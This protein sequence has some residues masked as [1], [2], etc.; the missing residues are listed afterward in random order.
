MSVWDTWVASRCL[1]SQIARCE[2]LFKLGMERSDRAVAIIQPSCFVAISLPELNFVAG[3]AVEFL[4]LW[5]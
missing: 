5:Y 2:T 4:D 1:A 3:L